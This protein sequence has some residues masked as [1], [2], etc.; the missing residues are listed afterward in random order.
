MT[1]SISTKTTEYT[2]GTSLQQP[3]IPQWRGYNPRIAIQ[4][5]EAPH[6]GI[7]KTFWIQ[8]AN[9]SAEKFDELRQEVAENE[10]DIGGLEEVSVP[11]VLQKIAIGEGKDGKH[12]K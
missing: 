9:M 4:S 11:R 6:S 8:P 2:Q 3:Y 5:A 1:S 12:I 10:Q 7:S